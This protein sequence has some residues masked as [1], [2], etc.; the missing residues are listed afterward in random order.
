MSGLQIRPFEERHVEDA[1][2]LLATRHAQ[3]RKGQPMLAE[4]FERA[5]DATRLVASVFGA[6][7]SSGAV[8]LTRSGVSGF[9]IG[10]P[11]SVASWGRKVWVDSAG[12]AVQDAEVVRDLYAVAADRWVD[13]GRSAHY[14]VVPCDDTAV[15]DAW[16]RLGFG[17]QHTHALRSAS[18]PAV[19]KPGR[20]VVRRAERTDIAALA[21]LDLLLPS[22]QS[23]SPVFV[24]APAQTIEQARAEWEDSIDDAEFANFVAVVDGRV[25]GSA[26]GC[27]V[28]HSSIH[29]GVARPVDAG[30]LAFAAVRPESRGRGI[31][32]ALANAV[33]TWIAES[34]YRSA[35]IDWRTTNLLSS[36][37]WPKLG[38]QPT[39]LRLHRLIGH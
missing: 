29:T 25:V 2:V 1:G 5:Q 26:V 15:V 9:L 35:V 13:E 6:T 20:C 4:R 10:A 32:R 27:S 34:G 3:H 16:F 23:R 18:A 21:E 12:H 28:T 33:H 7:D 39:F 19:R 17:Q 37:T 31:G 24:R 8:A 14:V 38:Y 22:H 36:R 30:L 11:Q